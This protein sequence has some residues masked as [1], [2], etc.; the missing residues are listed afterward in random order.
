MLFEP[1]RIPS[2]Y[3]Q[4]ALRNFQCIIECLNLKWVHFKSPPMRK[5]CDIM[6]LSVLKEVQASMRFRIA[7][8]GKNRHSIV[9]TNW[10]IIKTSKSNLMTTTKTRQTTLMDRKS[11]FRRHW[12]LLRIDRLCRISQEIKR[13]LSLRSWNSKKKC[14]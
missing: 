13:N 8:S 4:E 9:E 11:S 10:S 12:T 2:A 7:K 6:S 1:K 5:S 3:E 14:S